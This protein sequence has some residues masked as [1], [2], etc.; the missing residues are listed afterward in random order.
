[1]DSRDVAGLLLLTAAAACG[2]RTDLPSDG[3]G[4][5]GGASSSSGSPSCTITIDKGTTVTALVAE[6]ERIY[7]V[8]NHGRVMAVDADTGAGT[9][10][11][12]IPIQALNTTIALA[13]DADWLYVTFFSPGFG[14]TALW[15]ISKAGGEPKLIAPGRINNV[16]V[17]ETG[18][19]W[20]NWLM[21]QDKH[22]VFRRRPD[23]TVLSLGVVDQHHEELRGIFHGTAGLLVSSEFALLA[24]DIEGAGATKLSDVRSLSYPFERDGMLFYNVDPC[25]DSDFDPPCTQYGFYR[26]LPDGTM[27]QRIYNGPF[28]RVITDG[29]YWVFTWPIDGDA[30]IF[31]APYPDGETS[32]V[33]HSPIYTSPR[34]VALTPTRLVLG[35][36]WWEIGAGIQS[37]CRDALGL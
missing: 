16:F 17:D 7:Y 34:A 23:G 36:A 37:L 24:F 30:A 18:L 21:L 32:F 26:A 8:A 22:V 25:T 6:G 1:M 14:P 15:Q 10:L 5:A 9:V 19:Y 13:L 4:A 2:A 27:A 35:T 11:A 3:N 29:V 33:H 12:Q 28:E 20:T 31:G